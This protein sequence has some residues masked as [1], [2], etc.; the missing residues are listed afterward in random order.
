FPSVEGSGSASS[1]RVVAATGPAVPGVGKYRY[2]ATLDEGGMADV[3]LAVTKD[4]GFEKIVVIKQLRDALA[5]DPSF[6]AM[7]TDEARLAARLNHPNVVQTLE[8][9]SEHGVHFL[10]MEFLEGISY[11]RMARLKEQR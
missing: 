7:F 1:I 3:F 6:V 9:G 2:I 4:T 8:V 5:E 10:A 11:V